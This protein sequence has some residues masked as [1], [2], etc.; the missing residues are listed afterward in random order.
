MVA[1]GLETGSNTTVSKNTIHVEIRHARIISSRARAQYSSDHRV[2]TSLETHESLLPSVESFALQPRAGAGMFTLNEHREIN[3][4]KQQ[5]IC[6]LPCIS[7]EGLPVITGVS[8]TLQRHKAFRN[9]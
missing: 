1:V 5:T 4:H 8:L 6:F 7:S 2:S 9:R 3:P